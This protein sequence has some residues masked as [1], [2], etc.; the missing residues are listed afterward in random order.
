VRAIRQQRHASESAHVVVAKFAA[1]IESEKHVRVQRYGSFWRA[2]ADFTGHAQM[3]QQRAQFRGSLARF[4]I[5]QQIFSQAP[6][7]RE[8]AAGQI[9]FQRRRIV[10]EIRLAQ[11]HAQNAAARQ[12]FPQSA[13]YCFNFR[14]FGHAGPHKKGNT[15]EKKSLAPRNGSSRRATRIC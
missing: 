5:E 7:A 8:R 15:V 3:N 1:I 4:Q 6:D 11:A 12:N 10:N 2:D 13:R 9:L 14:Q